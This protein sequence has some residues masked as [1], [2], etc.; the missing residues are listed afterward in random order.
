MQGMMRSRS[1]LPCSAGR[2]TTSA[3]AGMT[4]AQGQR[5]IIM[6]RTMPTGAA[7]PSAASVLHAC[8]RRTH[9][10]RGNEPFSSLHSSRM[11]LGHQRHVALCA[12]AD[13]N[14][15]QGSTG[16]S[17]SPSSGSNG[18]S[19]SRRRHVLV[20]GGTGRVGSGTAASLIQVGPAAV[21][22]VI[23]HGCNSA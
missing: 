11:R 12:A 9:Q 7:R 1:S 8:E 13:M 20:L 14:Q 4:H 18:S 10:R 17:T 21:C 15:Q 16:D 6:Q 19:G 22:R 2:G 5:H 3:A 23:G